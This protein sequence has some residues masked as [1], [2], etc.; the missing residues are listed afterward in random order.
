MKFCWSPTSSIRTLI[1]SIIA[2]QIIIFAVLISWLAYHCG[3]NA[4]Q[5]NSQQIFSIIND[6]ISKTITTYLEEPYRL[7]KVHK[8][9]IR[10]GQ[11]DFSN[12]QQRDTYFVNMLK[13][14][15]RVTNTYFSMVNGM[16]YGARKE[17]NGAIVVWNSNLEKKKSGA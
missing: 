12:E 17:D 8:N 10:N 1:V 7:E 14:F 9:I 4:V 2:A 16:E 5:D 3:M 11:I 15:P 6:E 13:A